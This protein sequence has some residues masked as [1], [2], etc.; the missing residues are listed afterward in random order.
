[1]SFVRDERLEM[2]DTFAGV[3]PDHPT[4]AGEWTTR[5]LL[6]HLIV[7]ERRPDAAAGIAVRQLASYTEKVRLQVA[8]KP[9]DELV[10]S[11]RKGAPFWTWSAIPLVGDKANLFEFYVHH[12]DIRRAVDGWEP[13]AHDDR[14]ETALWGGLKSMGKLLF[15][16]SP[17]GV[18]LAPAGRD[19]VVA[20][21][22]EPHVR[23]V[24]EPSEIAL[25]AFGRPTER[26]RVV[27]QGDPGDV[28]SFEASPRGI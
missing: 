10:A 4:L 25:V 9:Y 16:K 19:D 20:H 27:I 5:D 17:V 15:R 18:V 6:A 12:E 3:G 21:K 1:M 14:R 28:A 2:C 24:G 13:R 8:E 26:T 22:G 23:L 11:F 7:R